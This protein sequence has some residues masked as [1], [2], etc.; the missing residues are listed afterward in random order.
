VKVYG[1][2]PLPGEQVQ[3][4]RSLEEGFVPEILDPTMLDGKFLVS[5]AD[6]VRAVRELAA[7]EAIFAGVSSG[8]VLVAAARVASRMEGGTIVA[9]LADGGWKYLSAGIWDRPLEQLGDELESRS[10]W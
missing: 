8:A 7:K 2:E 4:L 10:L 5:A 6:S 9:L 3:G 1:A